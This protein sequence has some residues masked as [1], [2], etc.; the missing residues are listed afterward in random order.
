MKRN[1]ERFKAK[2]PPDQEHLES[3]WKR[4]AEI[5][6]EK[7]SLKE[8]YR[9]ANFLEKV[10]V[11]KQMRSLEKEANEISKRYGRP[12]GA[13]IRGLIERLPRPPLGR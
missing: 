11:M 13:V 4:L 3:A 8:K 2:I 9:N 5:G 1:I 6:L 10:S 12:P 7:E